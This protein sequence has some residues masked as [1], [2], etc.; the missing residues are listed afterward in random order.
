M[1]REFRGREDVIGAYEEWSGREVKRPAHLQGKRTA[2][3]RSITKPTQGPTLEKS[4]LRFEALRN[5]EDKT[6]R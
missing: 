1:V 2:E 4:P 6:D 5:D 3:C